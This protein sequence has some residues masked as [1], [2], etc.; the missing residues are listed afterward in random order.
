MN[1]SAHVPLALAALL[2]LCN[3]VTPGPHAASADEAGLDGDAPLGEHD[4]YV[5]VDGAFLRVRVQG[6]DKSA[7]PVLFLHGYG[8]RLE[9]WRAVQPAVSADRVAIS[10]DQRG[11]GLSERPEGPYGPERH[12]DDAVAVL[13]ALGIERAIVVGHSYGGGV[14]LRMLLRHPERV[15]GLVLVDTFALSTQMPSSFHVAKTPIVGEAIFGAFFDEMPGEKYLL[16]FHDAQRFATAKSLEEMKR[17]M[18]RP[19][20]TYAALET[21]RGMDYDAVEADYAAAVVDVPRLIVWGEDDRVT[22]LRQ[23]KVLA[24]QL[25]SDIVVIPQ[26]GH[27]PSWERPRVVIDAIARVAAL[28]STQP[29]PAP[30]KPEPP[31][32]PEAEAEDVDEEAVTP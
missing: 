10:F 3:C 19:G 15:A 6:T 12:A 25:D 32:E 1:T 23:G 21:V 30:K 24:A 7:V 13:Q 14:A 22:P 26:C 27:M 5:D 4:R 9:G 18:A 20:S 2:G 31:E 11:F 8:S 29:K 17:L 28:A 16:A